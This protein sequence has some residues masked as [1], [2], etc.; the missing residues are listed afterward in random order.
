MLLARAGIT[1]IPIEA[2][3]LNLGDCFSWGLAKALDAPLRFKG[4]D[5]PATDMTAAPTKPHAPSW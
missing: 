2:A 3:G 1:T 4:D 5:I